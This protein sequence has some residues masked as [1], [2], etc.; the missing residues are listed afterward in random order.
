MLEEVVRCDRLGRPMSEVQ[1][2]GYWLG[3]SPPNAG[4]KY[5]PEPLTREEAGR[6]MAVCGRGPA[7]L[8]NRAIIATGLRT[9]LRDMEL[10]GLELRDVDLQAGELRVREGKGRKARV[11]GIDGELCALLE[12]W[13]RVR[14]KLGAPPRSGPFF[15]TITT[16]NVGRPVG[17]SYLR[18]TLPRL[19][20]RAGIE[21]RVHMHG[22]RHTFAWWWI[23]EGKPRDVLQKALG[24]GSSRTTD[25]YTDH[26]RP[27]DVV[28]T[29]RARSWD[30]P[31]DLAAMLQ[32][33]EVLAKLAGLLAGPDDE[34]P[35]AA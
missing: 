17:P 20:R 15:C 27:A 9:G 35:A 25:R 32:R 7:G 34:L 6:L 26:L 23:R 1:A 16:G 10:R 18:N 28:D 31:D 2:I 12:K 30:A 4:K 21:K 22:L 24:H 14:A 29:M 5:P 11:L 13:L 33:P 19:G 8:R 3:K